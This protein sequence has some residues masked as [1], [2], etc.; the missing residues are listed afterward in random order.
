MFAIWIGPNIGTTIL[1]FWRRHETWNGFLLVSTY[2]RQADISAHHVLRVV[3]VWPLFNSMQEFK[4][5]PFV[6]F[7][8]CDDMFTLRDE[9]HVSIAQ[10]CERHQKSWNLCLIQLFV[11]LTTNVRAHVF[12]PSRIL[13]LLFHVGLL[14]VTSR[15]SVPVF[16]N[17][18]KLDVKKY[19]TR[20]L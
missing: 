1:V 20:G 4:Y 9:W 16:G 13:W 12:A 3:D 19:N 18:K 11:Y 6:L 15:L 10:S 2:N 8:Y 5:G 7:D 17:E 14:K